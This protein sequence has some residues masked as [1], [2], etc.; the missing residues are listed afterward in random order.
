M[1]TRKRS[2]KITSK[3]NERKKKRVNQS[4]PLI[5]SLTSLS[6]RCRPPRHQPCKRHAAVPARA[7]AAPAPLLVPATART[8][9]PLAAA[10]PSR[11]WHRS[12]SSCSSS[13][14]PP[15]RRSPPGEPWSR[16]RCVVSVGVAIKSV[17][18]GIGRTRARARERSKRIR[19]G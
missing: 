1:R 9:A 12:S 8:R 4:S 2:R 15:P 5:L 17:G 6:P 11:R 13:P 7:T 18:A 14:L 19:N 10:P 3:K 16:K